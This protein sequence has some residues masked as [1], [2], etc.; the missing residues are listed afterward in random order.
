[1]RDPGALGEIAGSVD[2]LYHQIGDWLG[3]A[4]PFLADRDF[5][6][7]SLA[8]WVV[9]LTAFVIVFTALSLV[10]SVLLGRVRHV[11]ESRRTPAIDLALRLVLR[12][13]VAIIAAV[14]LMLSVRGLDLPPGIER[15]AKVIIVALVGLQG[16]IWATVIVDWVL[17]LVLA[18]FGRTTTEAAEQSLRASMAAVRFLGLLVV[19]S[20]IVIIALDNLGVNVTAL[21]TGMGI[22]GVAVALASQK[23]LGDVFASLSILFDKP[24]E[25]GDFIVIGDI[26]GTVEQIGIK[27]TR[28]RALSGEQVVIANGDLLASRI[29]NFK[30]MTERRVLFNIGVTYQTPLDK[31]AAIPGL[32]RQAIESQPNT[33]FDRAH[34]HRF[35]NSALEFEAVY[36]MKVP[37]YNAYMDTQERV[38]LFLAERLRNLGVEFA[39][40]TQTLYVIKQDAKG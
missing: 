3:K 32:I 35:G 30:R 36:F 8:A 5:F 12:T 13:S 11:Q 23:I 14:S 28:L 29:Q 18:R 7:N 19:Y 27:T 16:A 33:R 21:I 20:L 34:F 9:A 31:V 40:P 37:D 17:V 2:S 25:V 4:V 15:G 39:Y 6:G 24:F 1:M 10:R 22:G 38:N 26:R